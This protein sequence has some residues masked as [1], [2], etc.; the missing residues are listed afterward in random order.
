MISTT[1]FCTRPGSFHVILTFLA[2]WFLK[3]RFLNDFPIETDVKM[4]FL[5][6]ASPDPREAV[7]LY[8]VRKLSSKSELF[9]IWPSDSGEQ[10]I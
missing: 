2:L 9:Y 1:L 3:G 10:I 7:I 6:V 4:F 5:F 8:Y